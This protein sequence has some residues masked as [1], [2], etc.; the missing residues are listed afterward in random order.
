MLLA[1]L[2]FLSLLIKSSILL[3]VTPY[4]KVKIIFNKLYNE[5]T[6]YSIVSNIYSIIKLED[7][8]LHS[9]K[10][11]TDA[12]TFINETK[13]LLVDYQSVAIAECTVPKNT[14][15]TYG[16]FPYLSKNNEIISANSIA[17]KSIIYN[18]IV[19]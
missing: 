10:S 5:P 4:Q 15:F 12:I 3:N 9:F 8:W 1:I 17:A 19:I 7:F 2:N 11:L 14:L 16:N 6:Y 18:S 13:P